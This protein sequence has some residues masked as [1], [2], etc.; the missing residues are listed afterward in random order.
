MSQPI[1]VS[2]R[3]KGRTCLRGRRKRAILV[4][5]ILRK[6]ERNIETVEVY[7]IQFDNQN[8]KCI[9]DCIVSV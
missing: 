9:S 8:S 7:N 5:G 4:G 3:E 1:G 6:G 2:S